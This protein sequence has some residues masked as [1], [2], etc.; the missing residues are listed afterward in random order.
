MKKSLHSC[1][2][3]SVF[4]MAENGMISTI[5]LKY[6]WEVRRT[7]V[8]VF[9]HH[10]Y[11]TCTKMRPPS[12]NASIFCDS[13]GTP[14]GKI[15]YSDNH[16]I[17]GVDSCAAFI[18]VIGFKTPPK[19]GYIFFGWHSKVSESKATIRVQRPETSRFEPRITGLV[20]TIVASSTNI[21]ILIPS[22]MFVSPWCWHLFSRLSF[23]LLPSPL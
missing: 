11:L 1:H 22:F 7:Q 9:M 10:F 12:Y 16:T 21:C 23:G 8:T 17:N 19:E 15:N 3:I 5:N 13:F 14:H 4:Q 2:F 18:I 20:L 6:I